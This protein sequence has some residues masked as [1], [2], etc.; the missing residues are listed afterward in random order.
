LNEHTSDPVLKA[1]SNQIQTRSLL[2]DPGG[3]SAIRASL[4]AFRLIAPACPEWYYTFYEFRGP[5]MPPRLPAEPAHT[6]RQAASPEVFEQQVCLL[7]ANTNVAVAVTVSVAAILTFLQWEVVSHW[8]LLTWFTSMAGISVFR[9]VLARYY[10]RIDRRPKETKA[11]AFAFTLGSALSAAGWGA[12]GIWL[13]PAASFINQVLL[14]FILG[15]MMLGAASV[16]AARIEAFLSFILFAGI[17]VTLRLFLQGDQLHTAMALLGAIFTAATVRT[18]W[19]I[20]STVLSSLELGFENR[21]LV[22]DLQNS[23]QRAERLNSE[24][25]SEITIRKR[26]A[27]AVQEN[28]RRLQLALLGADLGLWDWNLITGKMFVDDRWASMLG[29]AAAEIDSDI[30]AWDN[31]IHPDDICEVRKALREH[32]E[33]RSPYYESEHRMLTKDGNWKWIFTR[34]KV[35]DRDIDGRPKRIT[36]TNRDVTSNKLAGEE[37]RRSRELLESRVRERTT[38]LNRT[39]SQLEEEITE[40][41]RAEKERA[42]IQAQLQHAQK[43]QATGTLAGGIAHDFNNI[44]TSIS[45]YAELARALLDEHTTAASYIQQILQASRRAEDLVRRILL[46]SRKGTEVSKI[47]DIAGVVSEVLQLLRASI[48]SSIDIRQELDTGCGCISADPTLIHQVVMNLCTNAYQAIDGSIGTLTVTL[49]SEGIDDHRPIVC[50]DLPR[51]EYVRLT[52]SDTGRG[53]PREIADRVFEPF[54]S[55]KDIGHGTGLGLSVVHGIVTGC[56]GVVTFETQVGQ[57]TTF[58]VYLP[59]ASRS[60][61]IKADVPENLPKGKERILLVDDEAAIAQLGA[62]ILQGLGYTVATRTSSI[63]ALE[64]FASEPDQFDAIVSDFSMPRMTGGEL[65]RRV[66]QV[67]PH[68]PVILM[69][70]FNDEVISAEQAKALGIGEFLKKPFSVLA[71]AQVVRNVLDNR[72]VTRPAS[73]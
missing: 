51:G 65:V 29:Y 56:G 63:E 61:S 12:A 48:P 42:T 24:L 19:Q 68:I 35:V 36:G 59:R 57:G 70:G 31:L 72:A 50:R 23:T 55:T 21:A 16:L 2:S 3:S 6:F 13:Y 62:Q 73:A 53:I 64:L 27:E 38:E 37:L 40:R 60:A 58:I 44:L 69:S 11:W 14:A 47:I 41:K 46:F 4:D 32:T 25:I 10:R 54:F 1:R 28:E 71:M 43:M 39:V 49:T 52:V 7:Y 30:H 22:K 15:G 67:R 18:A 66:R 33:G 17:P 20:H 26:A 5:F 45:G 9:F 34:G 8:V